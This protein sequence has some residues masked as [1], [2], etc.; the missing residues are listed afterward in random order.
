M[1][2][3]TKHRWIDSQEDVSG[4]FKTS[5]GESFPRNWLDLATADDLARVGI[6]AYEY[7][8]PP[9][10]EPTT[11]EIYPPLAKYQFDA[12]VDYLGLESAITDYINTMPAG[13]ERSLSRSLFKNGV[14]GVYRRSSPLF[15]QIA[16]SDSVPIDSDEIDAA[17]ATARSL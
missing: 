12:M 15:N 13:I 6:E 14:D 8:P 10:P 9:K 7:T 5:T 4:A 1:T 2:T 3:I 11:D 16:E 17:W